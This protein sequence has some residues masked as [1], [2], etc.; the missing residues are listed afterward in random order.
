MGRFIL[1]LFFFFQKGGNAMIELK[2][3]NM[4]CGHCVSTV[5]KT[6]K[7]LDPQASVDVDL[8]AKR[9]RV[10]TGQPLE[11]LRKALDTAGY[12]AA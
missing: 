8:E 5:T 2:I 7:A 3:D 4:T 6:L 10:E 1:A 11:A 9:V 12:P